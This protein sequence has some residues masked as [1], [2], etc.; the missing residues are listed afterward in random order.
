MMPFYAANVPTK[1]SGRHPPILFGRTVIK[2]VVQSVFVGGPPKI[3]GWNSPT[4]SFGRSYHFSWA[5]LHD[6]YKRARKLVDEESRFSCRSVNIGI[7]DSYSRIALASY[8]LVLLA[9]C[10]NQLIGLMGIAKGLIQART[11]V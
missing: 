6:R 11:A 2:V 10:I 3:S 5:V 7:R 9:E 4:I 1:I 8:G